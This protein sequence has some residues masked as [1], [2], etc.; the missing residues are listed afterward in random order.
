MWRGLFVYVY[1]SGRKPVKVTGP[2]HFPRLLAK[3]APHGVGNGY[4]RLGVAST[5]VE[6][7][8]AK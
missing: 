3:N 5:V 6:Q 7:P 1:A 8:F 2:C 4:R